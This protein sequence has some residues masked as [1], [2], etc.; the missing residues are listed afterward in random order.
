MP[1][2]ITVKTREG[3][4]ISLGFETRQNPLTEGSDEYQMQRRYVTTK[5]KTTVTE[6]RGYDE[7]EESS[8]SMTDFTDN[9]AGTASWK[10][11]SVEWV[12]DSDFCVWTK[13]TTVQV[14]NMAVGGWYGI[15]NS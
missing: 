2:F 8:S 14:V 13:V 11:T 9:G 4:N 3:E 5:T 15:S 7:E 10:L 12:K 6:E 1:G